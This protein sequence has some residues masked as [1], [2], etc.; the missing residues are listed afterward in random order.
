MKKLILL[1]LVSTPLLAQSPSIGV[2]KN[3]PHNLVLLLEGKTITKEYPGREV[4]LHAAG[5]IKKQ[6]RSNSGLVA[7]TYTDE[8]SQETGTAWVLADKIIGVFVVRR[9]EQRRLG[10]VKV[11]FP[12]EEK[13]WFTSLFN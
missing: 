5:T 13:G 7:L 6:L 1:L 10:E 9:I 11:D 4:A 12:P 3:D 2:M 8:A